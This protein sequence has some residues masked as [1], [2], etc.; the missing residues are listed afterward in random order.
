[1]IKTVIQNKSKDQWRNMQ[2]FN[3][4]LKGWWL[5]RNLEKFWQFLTLLMILVKHYQ[6]QKRKAGKN[7]WKSC[8][9][10]ENCK[11]FL[12]IYNLWQIICHLRPIPGFLLNWLKND[13]QLKTATFKNRKK[14]K[15]K[16]NMVRNHMCI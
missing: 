16:K 7:Q 8:K 13:K 6:N 5:Q 1:M 4:R 15:T 3:G 9:I 12:A 11:I 14:L 10:L 2:H